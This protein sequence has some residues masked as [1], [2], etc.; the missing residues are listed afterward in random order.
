MAFTESVRAGCT[1]FEHGLVSANGNGLER[2]A[3]NASIV[4]TL[5]RTG[6]RHLRLNN[7][8]SAVG[9]FDLPIFNTTA[10]VLVMSFWFYLPSLPGSSHFKL[11]RFSTNG[12]DD[13]CV[14]VSS[15]GVLT[16]HD[17]DSDSVRDTG[18]TIAAGEWHQIDVRF[19]VSTSTEVGSWTVDGVD[20]GTFNTLVQNSTGLTA[21]RLGSSVA[22]PVAFDIYYDDVAWTDT[23]GDYPIGPV[24]VIWLLP[25]ADGTH[26][27]AANQ[28][29]S[30][31]SGGTNYANGATTAYQNLDDAAPWSTTRSTTD[32]IRQDVTGT[33]NYLEIAPQTD[34]ARSGETALAVRALL[35]Y[36]ST[37]TTADN[38]S[39]E[40]FNSAGT[41]RDLWGIFSGTKQDYSETSNFFKGRCAAKPAGDWTE[42]E[43]EATRI[44][45]G[46]STD[47]SPVPTW[48]MLAWEVAYPT[49][50]AGGAVSDV[51]PRNRTFRSLIV[52]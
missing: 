15:A 7:A 21:L 29:D 28:F 35:A 32:S 23:S 11:C 34:A 43:I 49:P 46:G 40:V 9:N 8:A 16:A 26:N 52:R 44:R 19:D 2:G 39:C 18:P 42:S 13:W 5:P 47:V 22:Q 33:A 1:G 36:S 38:G 45:I 10:T 12:F 14:R 31:D 6:A 20:Q 25:G 3:T 50:A 27:A 41:K 51:F 48:Q 24:D 17:E 37:S 30:G 4:T